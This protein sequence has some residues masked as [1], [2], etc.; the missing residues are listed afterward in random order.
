MTDPAFEAATRDEASI[1]E[2]NE[3]AFD[4]GL[5]LILD[6]CARVGALARVDR[7]ARPG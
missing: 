2:L 3:V 6:E 5:V 7:S 4:R 1:D